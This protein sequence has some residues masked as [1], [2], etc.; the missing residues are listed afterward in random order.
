[1]HTLVG[2]LV[3]LSVENYLDVSVIYLFE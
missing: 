1:M 3:V 2:K